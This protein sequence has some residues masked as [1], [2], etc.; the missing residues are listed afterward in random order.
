MVT[1]NGIYYDLTKS[2]Y[3]FKTPDTHVTYVFSSDLHLVKFE[4]NY[5]ENR[6]EQN[7]KF[8]ARFRLNTHLNTLADLLLYMKIEQRGFLV[9][10]ER[11]QKLCHE[12]L[13]L[14]GEQATQKS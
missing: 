13:I 3:K 4:D 14:S 8:K 7:I 2:T 1:R 5:L 9:V 11:G 12:N 10:N 6:K